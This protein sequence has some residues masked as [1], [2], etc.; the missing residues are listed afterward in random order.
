[1]KTTLYYIF[2]LSGI[3]P[4]F[5]LLG[6]TLAILPN[7]FVDFHFRIKEVLILSTALLGISG[8]IGLLRLS[9]GLDRKNN[10]VTVLLLISGIIGSTIFLITTGG[11]RAFHWIATF[12]EPGEWF[13]LV[14]PNI[15]S[16]TFTIV[17]LIKL[18]RKWIRLTN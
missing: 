11:Q 17:L 6:L 16:A 3:L 8:F 2:L 9:S 12:E 1:M 5:I 7:L 10:I 14:W 15:V 4:A 18:S 13:I